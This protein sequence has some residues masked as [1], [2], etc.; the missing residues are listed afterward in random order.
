[1][2]SSILPP[3]AFAEILELALREDLGTADFTPESDLTA[4]WTV[5]SHA[6]A[7][8]AVI[9]RKPGVVAGLD[10]ARAVFH[11]LDSD[12]VFESLVTDGDG[13]E[14]GDT[15]LRMEGP[16]RALLT[17]ERTALNFLQRLS[18]VATLTRIYVDAIAGTQAR[19]TDTRKTTPG[20]RLLE[21]YAVRLGGGRNHRM[22]LHDA[23]LIKENHGATVGGVKAAIQLARQ[24]ARQQGRKDVQ[25]FAEARDLDEIRSVLEAVPDRIL[26][27]NMDVEQMREAVRLIRQASPDIDI[28][29]TGNVT[30]D[31]VLEIAETGVDLI[32]IGA[33]THSAPALNLSM[34]FET[35]T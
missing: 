32:S 11:R 17:G 9:A 18:G 26:L 28:E 22:G 10:V 20:F 3:A 12:V 33:L 31:N 25:I 27:D 8:A 34:L 6:R 19:I 16:A 23:V 30:L 29:A 7:R 21:K 14:S 1:M 15:L 13:V 2:S 24:A 35:E 4:A 5:P